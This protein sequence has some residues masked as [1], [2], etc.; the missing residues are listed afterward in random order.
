[1]R[2]PGRF[3]D[4]SCCR[5]YSEQP[6]EPRVF[7]GVQAEVTRALASPDH[8]LDVPDDAPDHFRKS[9]GLFRD[10]MSD[11]RPAFV[12][13]DGNYVSARWPGDVHAFAVEFSRKLAG[14]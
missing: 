1:M 9:S 12:V 4:R 10:S 14:S 3:R 7:P 5:T 11:A 2:Y 13:T 6:A 8:S